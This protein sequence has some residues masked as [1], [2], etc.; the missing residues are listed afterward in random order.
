MRARGADVL[1]VVLRRPVTAVVLFACTALAGL[2]AWWRIPV[3]VLPPTS[4]PRLTVTVAWRGATPEA[5]EQLVT[6]RV[7]AAIRLVPDVTDVKSVTE[8]AGAAAYARLTVSFASK[9]NVSLTRV[10]V[11][12]RLAALRDELP[13]GLYGPFVQQYSPVEARATRPAFMTFIISGPGTPGDLAAY[14]DSTFHPVLGRIHGVADVAVTGMRPRVIKVSTR[15]DTATALRVTT[16]GLRDAVA[17]ASLRTPLGMLVHEAVAEPLVLADSTLSADAVRNAALPSS[18]RRAIRV[19]DVADVVDTVWPARE[20]TRINGAS[21]VEL[22]VVR[23][24]DANVIALSDTVQRAMRAI[25][26]HANGRVAAS[27]DTDEGA[28]LRSVL[29][30]LRRCAVY[31]LGAVLV[32]LVILTRSFWAASVLLIIVA[33]A[34][35]VAMTGVY[36]VGW[37]MNIVTV[38]GIATGMSLSVAYAAIAWDAINAE[39][40]VRRSRRAAALRGVRRVQRPMITV[41]VASALVLIALLNLRGAPRDMYLPF[42]GSALMVLAVGAAAAVT[43]VPLA[44][45]MSARP[46]PRAVERAAAAA[47][48]ILAH[49]YE[50]ALRACLRHPWR[51][52]ALTAAIACGALAY[53][54]RAAVWGAA[55]SVPE[56]NDGIIVTIHGAEGTP[57]ARLDS[58]VARFENITR[59]ASGVQTYS[60]R[61]SA[62]DAEVRITLNAAG[63]S[64][65][66]SDLL[67]QQLE[68]L[69]AALGGFRIDVS[70]GGQ[71]QR[72]APPPPGYAI[73]LAG[74]DYRTLRHLAEGIREAL[75]TYP[76]VADVNINASA[77]VATAP[78]T[79]EV[80]V[81]PDRRRLQAYGISTAQLAATLGR[82]VGADVGSGT[83]DVGGVT[84]WIVDRNDGAPRNLTQLL[85]TI[86][87]THHGTGV[88]LGEIARLDSSASPAQIVRDS[89]QYH[90]LVTYRFRGPKQVG[91]NV[92]KAVS[93]S[94]AL[95]PG[96]TLSPVL[97]ETPG[98]VS[99]MSEWQVVGLVAGAL[100][101]VT[102]AALF[103]SLLLPLNVVAVVPVGLAS[104]AAALAFLRVPVSQDAC[105]GAVVVAANGLVLALFVIER[106][107]RAECKATLGVN[108]RVVMSA[109]AA[110]RP[111]VVTVAVNF[112][113]ALP[114]ALAGGERSY[115]YARSIV[116]LFGMVGSGLAALFLIP[117][118]YAGRMRALTAR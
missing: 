68:Q 65:G 30:D 111:V 53:F 89:Q 51:V 10:A 114:F 28:V 12:D 55:W 41:T 79:P 90:R 57:L 94:V 18:N 39:C 21:A 35:V 61:E 52:V 6:S 75:A 31:A 92:M 80:I 101:F 93:R 33:A 60:A 26:R 100:V 27:L 1:A 62:P 15:P 112:A 110:A 87:A 7:V 117:V 82:S 8:A 54:A 102:L 38:L 43:L 40:V 69:A 44:A 11:A 83:I 96:Y 59:H 46:A 98:A 116:V 103:E 88:T 106:C 63:V 4:A 99:T 97:P 45:S 76:Q 34:A 9:A 49:I 115:W 86:V 16:D 56:S 72:S 66:S 95:P 20:I 58:I 107:L 105:A 36:W 42:A 29:D 71:A 3:A 25:V 113:V 22:S 14:V 109:L 2:A 77:R 67:L 85:Q 5:A 64:A 32:L 74:Y 24:N 48:T 108:D 73:D 37:T 17:T 50:Q 91:D 104:A 84:V 70:T 78:P 23:D 81:T 118:L 13:K 19:S 47:S